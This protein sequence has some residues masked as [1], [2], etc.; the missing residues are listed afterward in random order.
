MDGFVAG[1]SLFWE[2]VAGLVTSQRF[3]SALALLIVSVLIIF[4][5]VM[6]LLQPDFEVLD[7]PDADVLE[8][9]LTIGLNQAVLAVGW[10]VGAVVTV[11][12]LI[13]SIE[14]HPPTLSAGW[15]T[16]GETINKADAAPN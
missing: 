15:Q 14:A 6:P 5:G 4:N 9:E 2:K 1:L 3:L 8:A 7:V 16:R 13:G 10:L 11:L 12:R